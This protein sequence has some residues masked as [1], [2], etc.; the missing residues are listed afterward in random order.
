M[1]ITRALLRGLSLVQALVVLAALSFAHPAEAIPAFARKYGTSCVTCHTVYPKLNPFG[2]AFRRNNYRFPGVDSDYVK[3]EPIPLGQEAYKKTFPN[4]VWPG[5]LPANPLSFGFL[6][7]ATF[8]PDVHSSGGQADNGAAITVKDLIAEAHIW[9]GGSFSDTVSFFGEVTFATSGGVSVEHGAVFFNDLFFGP[10]ILNLR[11]GKTANTLTSFGMHS[12][13]VA[14]T[15]LPPLGVT[16]I[17]GSPG[18][19]WNVADKYTGIEVNGIIGG[20]FNYAVG[21]NAGTNFNVKSSQTVYAHL[22]VK[23]GGIR[24]DGEQGGAEPDS[25]KPWAE[26]A[27]TLD[28]FALRTAS[29][30]QPVTPP[31]GSTLMLSDNCAAG[32]ANPSGPSSP[33]LDDEI[34]AFGGSLRGQLA[35]FELNAG[36]YVERHSHATPDNF[37]ATAITQFDEL[38]YVV[39]PWLVPAVRLELSHVTPNG[40]VFGTNPYQDLRFIPGIAALVQPNIKLTL[41]AQFEHAA[42]QFPDIGAPG[43]PSPVGSWS[44]ANGVATN[45]VKFENESL[46]L[47]MWFGF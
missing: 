5:N 35:S 47:G 37:G 29:N 7:A 14:D 38:S 28:T 27:L 31:M 12:S 32:L 19:S 41:V 1:K 40:G 26:K 2:E 45:P 25:T 13:Y 17:F 15:Y 46:S 6:G 18:D 36:A 20:R 11:L 39:F 24:M 42:G 30:F 43:M 23:I 8:H 34:L 3:Q 44:T 10:H 16:A 4:S 22:G 21:F 33:C 9:A